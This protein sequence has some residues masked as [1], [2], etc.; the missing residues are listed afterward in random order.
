MDLGSNEGV[1]FKLWIG[2]DVFVI[3]YLI[4]SIIF[5]SRFGALIKVYVACG[6]WTLGKVIDNREVN[7]CC[8]NIVALR[9]CLDEGKMREERKWEE[10]KWRGKK[11]RENVIP[12]HAWMDEGK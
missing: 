8:W 7:N 9:V 4:S 2:V 11:M 12:H 6:D 1:C 10:R 5:V 3:K